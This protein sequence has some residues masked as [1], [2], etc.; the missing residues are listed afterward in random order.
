MATSSNEA[1][2]SLGVAY[3]VIELLSV[4]VL[5]MARLFLSHFSSLL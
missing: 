5:Y 4:S 2:V 1:F 3:R